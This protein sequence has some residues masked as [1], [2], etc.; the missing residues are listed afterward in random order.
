MAKKTFKT[1][2]LPLAAVDL[3]GHDSPHMNGNGHGNGHNHNGRAAVME[4]KASHISVAAHN[5]NNGHTHNGGR[6]Q[7][8]FSAVGSVASHAPS[9]KHIHL[10]VDASHGHIVEVDGIVLTV[11]AARLKDQQPQN[12]GDS[13]VAHGDL[14]NLAAPIAVKIDGFHNAETEMSLHLHISVL[15]QS[16]TPVPEGG[17]NALAQHAEGRGLVHT[18]DHDHTHVHAQEAHV[19]GTHGQAVHNSHNGTHDGHNAAASHT[20][21]GQQSQDASHGS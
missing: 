3:N 13:H 12:S 16:R 1:D 6:L 18:D 21:E 9:H 5:S 10:H 17:L 15:A 14:G 11:G 19:N 20:K 2:E 4:Q 7:H 8:L